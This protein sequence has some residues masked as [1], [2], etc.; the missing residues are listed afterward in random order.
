MA[1]RSSKIP[2]DFGI[3]FA[4][5]VLRARG[6]MIVR[7]CAWHRRYHWYP[8]T[9]GI[10]SWSGFSVAFTDGMCRGCSIRFRDQW[11]LPPISSA[12]RFPGLSPALMRG[13]VTVTL[14]MILVLVVRSSDSERLRATTM[15]PPETV[16]APTPIEADPTSPVPGRPPAPRRARILASRPA[17]SSTVA[18]V[19]VRRAPDHGFFDADTETEALVL[20]SMIDAPD[21][22]SIE[23]STSSATGRRFAGRSMFAALP[24]AGLTNQAP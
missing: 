8:M 16:F 15:P 4:A 17:P 12:A 6:A 7:R 19:A 24:P 11:N 9:I 21:A 1:S 18:A 14:V 5:H 2:S 23:G 13:T 3:S 10:A 22:D 20:A